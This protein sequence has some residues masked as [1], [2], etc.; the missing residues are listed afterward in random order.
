ME[1]FKKEDIIKLGISLLIVYIIALI[2]SFI[3]YPEIS[4]WYASLAK[5]SW[6]PAGW[7]FPIVWNILYIL[8]SIGLFFVWK[9]G[10][11]DKKV[12]IALYVFAV[13]LGLNLLWSIVF[14][15]FHSLNGGLGIIILLWLFIL[16]NIIVFYRV[17]KLAGILLIPYIIWVTIAMYLNYTVYILNF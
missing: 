6:T 11:K 3:T 10:I 17:Y 4:T 1:N 8:M 15:G 5:P 16:L 2:G 12:K 13:Q 7:V 9:D 14:F